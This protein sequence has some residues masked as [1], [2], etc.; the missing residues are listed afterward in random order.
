MMAG[1]KVNEVTVPRFATGDATT[2]ERMVGVGEVSTAIVSVD[3]Y[4]D[5]VPEA[6]LF[7]LPYLFETSSAVA[8]VLDRDGRPGAGDLLG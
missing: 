2:A 6:D 3:R 8:T 7:S 4:A 1:T 5:R